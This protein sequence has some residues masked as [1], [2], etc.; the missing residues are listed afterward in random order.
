[1]KLAILSL[2]A[3]TLSA[4]TRLPIDQLKGP[5]GEV[6]L[7]ALDATGK[8]ST[9]TLGEGLEIIGGQIKMKAVPVPSGYALI[10]SEYQLARAEDGTYESPSGNGVYRNGLLMTMNSDY[11][12]VGGRI[13][14]AEPWAASDA[15]TAVS[16]RIMP[17]LPNSIALP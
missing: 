15:V 3:L 6:R 17:L 12:L 8:L 4:Q 7:L 10:R 2:F 16:Y 14:P 5:P 9:L 11:T 1:M 13:R